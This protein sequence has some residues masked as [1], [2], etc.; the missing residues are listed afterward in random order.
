MRVYHRTTPE[1]ATVIRR[2][3]EFTS[4]EQGWVYVG[5]RP[6]GYISGY[7]EGLVALEIPVELLELDD[8]FQDGEQHFRVR[9]ERILPEWVR[10]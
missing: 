9:A 4:K 10:G 8:E 2:T 5:S 7:G 1:A 6:D 3:R